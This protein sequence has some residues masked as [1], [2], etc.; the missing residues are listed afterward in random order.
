MQIGHPLESVLAVPVAGRCRSERLILLKRVAMHV[1]RDEAQQQQHH[2]DGS[3]QGPRGKETKKIII[4]KKKAAELIVE[5][6]SSRCQLK[7]ILWIWMCRCCSINNI[8][9]RE[10]NRSVIRGSPNPSTT[11]K[12]NQFY[13]NHGAQQLVVVG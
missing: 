1:N 12:R 3:E 4:I 6:S 9:V 2:T 5:W 10:D 13:P 8:P 7:E 11:Q